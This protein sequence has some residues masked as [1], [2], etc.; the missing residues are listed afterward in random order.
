MYIEA[1]RLNTN[2]TNNLVGTQNVRGG[3]AITMALT[4]TNS[5]IGV[6]RD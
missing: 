3:F 1:Y 4:L 6:L 2:A 5:S